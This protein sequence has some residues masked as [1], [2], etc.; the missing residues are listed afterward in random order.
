MPKLF[1]PALL[2]ALCMALFTACNQSAETTDNDDVLPDSIAIN[3]Y[4]LRAN[5]QYNDYI[6]AMQSCDGTTPAYKQQMITLLR[7][8]NKTI[9]KDKK[10][11]AYVHVAR[12]ELHDSLRMA[13]VFLE[14]TY[15]DSSREEILFP[16]VRTDD[17]WRIR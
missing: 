5:G 10:G 6:A 12:K 17:T 2:T 13:N 11:V 1:C 8:H 16:L 14:V 15:N 9:L 7:H 4:M 3:Y